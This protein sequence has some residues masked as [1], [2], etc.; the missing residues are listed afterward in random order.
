MSKPIHGG[1]VDAAMSE[2]GLSRQQID[3]FSASINPLGTP[4]EVRRALADALERIGDY[5]EIDATSLRADL[6]AFHH[7]PEKNLLPGSGSTELIY[8]LPRV[9]KPRRALLVQPC[10]SEYAPALR[11]ADCSIDTVSLVAEEGFA[12]SIEAVLSALQPDTD[13][14]L[15]ANPGNPTGVAI[16]PCQLVSLATQLGDRRLVVDEAFIDFCSQHSVLP[17]V[18]QLAN[19]L[20]LRSMTKFYAIPGVRV[21]YLAASQADIELLS[22]GKEPWTL[23][24]LAIAAGKACL[25]ATGYQ[26]QTLRLI[27]QLRDEL[28][29]GLEALGIKVF[30]SETNYLLCQMPPGIGAPINA[31]RQQ[32]ILIRGCGDFAPLD[33]S[34]FR[35]AVLSADANSRLLTSLE[36]LLC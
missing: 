21:G 24:N 29:R 33:D 20:V 22:A 28:A 30:T 35:V 12:F 8:L 23:S 2:L 19:L 7:L 3:D 25:A 4:P 18:T 5:P 36:K 11:Q 27:P 32:G 14:V 26:Q 15:L 31:L 10:F 6:A 34:F 17:Q 13:L 16:D 9:F 1:G